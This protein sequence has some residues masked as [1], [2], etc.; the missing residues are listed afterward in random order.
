MKFIKTTN[1]SRLEWLKLRTQGIGGSDVSAIMGQNPWRSA[2]RVWTEK[3]GRVALSDKDD[4][5]FIEWGNTMEPII[6]NK[7]EKATDKKVFRPNKEF[8]HPKYDFLR[9]N[10]DRD[11]EK[12]PGFVEIK[13]VHEFKSS[14]W[15]GDQVP[16]PYLFQVQHY[17]NVLNRPYVYFAYLIGGHHFD[18]KRVDKDQYFIDSF[19]P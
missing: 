19:T 5:E 2:Y 7:F 10:I 3:T 9:A 14:E 1:M 4:N 12:E 11:V 8:I 18:Y 13:T 17:M 16:A 6:A 15:D